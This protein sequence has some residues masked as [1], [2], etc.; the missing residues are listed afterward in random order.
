MSKYTGQPFDREGIKRKVI[1]N[2]I[3]HSD[4]FISISEIPGIC[5]KPLDQLS[6]VDVAN[7]LYAQISELCMKEYTAMQTK[8]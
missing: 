3:K 1:E 5:L 4:I 7:S 2:S 8:Y 6:N